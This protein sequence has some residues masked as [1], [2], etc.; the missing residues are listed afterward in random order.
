MQLNTRFVFLGEARDCPVLPSTGHR[1]SA[2]W[3]HKGSY[4][5]EIAL[6]TGTGTRLHIVA[7]SATGGFERVSLDGAELVAGSNSSLSPSGSVLLHNHLELSLVCGD[8][9]LGIENIDGF[10][11]LRSVTVLTGRW[12]RLASHGLLGQTW[13]SARYSGPV[14]EIEGEVDDYVIADNDVFGDEFVFNQ[15]GGETERP[16]VREL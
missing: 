15:F 8:Y 13:R 16:E 11:N 2:C 9:A 6:K 10:V 3:S 1:S 14:K 7:G 5:A 4:M 12:S